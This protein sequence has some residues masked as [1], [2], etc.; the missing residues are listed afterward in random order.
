MQK[1]K[2]VGLIA[3]GKKEN[4]PLWQ[5]MTDR[6]G[7]R[8][9]VLFRGVLDGLD[10]EE[11]ERI[12][13]FEEGENYI[14][15]ELPDKSTV[16]I[17]EAVTRRYVEKIRQE[18]FAEGAAA[19]LVLCTGDFDR[20]QEEQGLLVLPQDIIYGLL[21]GLKPGRTGFIVPE[22]GQI[23]QSEENYRDLHPVVRAASPYGPVEKIREA[24]ASFR[25][26]QVSLIVMDCMGFT[27]EL[28]QLAAE[29]SGKNVLVPRVVIPKII[30]SVV[31][32][33]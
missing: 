25:E 14:V 20:A 33:E 2:T 10:P 11:I 4:R 8:I 3:M 22:E 32:Q 30:R 16:H 15:T 23:R 5:D 21:S 29:E 17:S 12:F 28:G 19:V 6:F 13:A 1:K 9:E 24:A 31:E 18:M 26:E 27:A 7:S